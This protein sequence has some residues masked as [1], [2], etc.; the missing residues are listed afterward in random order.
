MGVYAGDH[1]CMNRAKCKLG[2]SCGP[3]LNESSPDPVIRERSCTIG[4]VQLH[5]RISKEGC[6]TQVCTPYRTIS[7]LAL[8]TAM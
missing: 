4:Y 8:S 3:S 5:A 7:L 2:R 1:L 6:G